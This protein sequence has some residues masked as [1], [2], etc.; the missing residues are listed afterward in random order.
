MNNK[1]KPDIHELMSLCDFD[2]VSKLFVSKQEEAY[3]EALS[4]LYELVN[5]NDKPFVIDDIVLY[6][7]DFFIRLIES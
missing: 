2:S 7:F 5:K 1:A 4:A 3:V 6:N